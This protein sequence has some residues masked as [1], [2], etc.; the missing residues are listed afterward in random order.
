MISAGPSD[1][2]WVVSR[3]DDSFAY[4]AH[5]SRWH[6]SARAISHRGIA[7]MTMERSVGDLNGSPAI[8]LT[9]KTLA[10]SLSVS[11]PLRFQ[12]SFSID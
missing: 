10:W 11:G 2:P 1:I 4:T 8:H 5:S 7:H 12:T 6:R 3:A 9:R